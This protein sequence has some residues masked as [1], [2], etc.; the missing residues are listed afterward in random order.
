[1]ASLDRTPKVTHPAPYP[2]HDPVNGY[3]ATCVAG[4]L[5]VPLGMLCSVSVCTNVGVGS[6]GSA[7]DAALDGR[8]AG[9]DPAGLAR[10]SR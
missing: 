9:R 4:R 5:K 6:D 10:V 1:M 8:V 3:V 7:R 2:H